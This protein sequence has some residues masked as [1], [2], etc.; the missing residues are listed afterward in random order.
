MAIN[1]LKVLVSH[2]EYNS[3]DICYMAVNEHQQKY[4]IEEKVKFEINNPI[5]KMKN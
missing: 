3:I 2:L 1:K 5:F 4:D